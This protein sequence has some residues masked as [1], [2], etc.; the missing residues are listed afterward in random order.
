MFSTVTQNPEATKQVGENLGQNLSPGS[1]VALTGELGSGKTTLV[2]GIGEGLRI[3]SL[4][5]SPSFVIINEY[6]GPLPLYHFDLYRLNNAQ[7]ILSLGY[8]EYFY[9]KRGVVVIEWAKKMKDFLPKEY[10]EI[11]LKI[12]N[13]VRKSFFNGVNLSKRKISGQAYGASY[14]EVIKKMEKLFC[15]C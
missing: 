10:L 5:K 8:E 14:R 11:N 15:S 9:E 13:P 7:E 1:I 2:Q 3:K 4:I 12:V 6:D